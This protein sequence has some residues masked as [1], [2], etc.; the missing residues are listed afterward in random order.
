M[1][2]AITINKEALVDLVKLK[3]EFNAVVESLELMA[4]TGFM[5]SYKKSKEQVKKREFDDWNA[6]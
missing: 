1:P 3:E 2:T 4:D 6:L 5:D